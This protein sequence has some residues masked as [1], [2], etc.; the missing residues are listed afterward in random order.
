[1]EVGGGVGVVVVPE[2]RRGSEVGVMAQPV[3]EDE[4]VF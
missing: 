1:L 2:V 3:L 4:V